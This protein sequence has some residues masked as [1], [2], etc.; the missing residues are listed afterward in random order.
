VLTFDGGVST[1]LWTAATG[2]LVMPDQPRQGAAALP[3]H[4]RG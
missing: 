3:V 4:H 2:D 1:Y